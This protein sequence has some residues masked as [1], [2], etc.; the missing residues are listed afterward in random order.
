[1]K[2][3]EIL[4]KLSPGTQNLSGVGGGFNKTT[5]EDI[6]HA[7]GG[8]KSGPTYAA[9]T[10]WV[11]ETYTH[12]LWAELIT[13]CI[14]RYSGPKGLLKSLCHAAIRELTTPLI[15]QTCNGVESVTIEGHGTIECGS[16]KGTGYNKITTLDRA[17]WLDVEVNHYRNNLSAPY[18][19]IY[20]KLLDWR[21]EAYY[22]LA[23]KLGI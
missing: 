16:C 11:D 1:M 13:E 20:S 18:E 8:L 14:D 6:A 3:D 21:Q 19:Y 23:K 12:R 15:C 2:P 9:L 10:C 5:P 22:H 4:A 7:L 17:G